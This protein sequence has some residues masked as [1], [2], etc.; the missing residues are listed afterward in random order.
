[1]DASLLDKTE[2]DALCA[3]LAYPQ[4]LPETGL[5]ARHFRGEWRVVFEAL[6]ALTGCS[7][8]VSVNALWE[9]MTATGTASRVPNLGWLMKLEREYVSGGAFLL[10]D[11]KRLIEHYEARELGA[12]TNRIA[13]DALGP[14][15]DLDALRERVAQLAPPRNGH[16]TKAEQSILKAL[17][18]GPFPKRLL[19]PPGL[20]GDVCQWINDT[21]FR[22]QPILT[23]ACV[24]PA[25]GALFGRRFHTPT[26]L[27]TNVYTIGVA[28]TGAGKQHARDQI[29]SLFTL[30]NCPGLLG[31]ER[32]ASGQG[33]LAA[34]DRS[35]SAIFMLDEF[36]ST[37]HEASKPNAAHFHR[38][39][40][41]ILLQLHS[42]AGSVFLG[43]E[44]AKR[45]K[46]ATKRDDIPN[47]NACLYASSTPET[48]YQ[49]LSTQRA[50]DGFLNRMLV[51]ETDDPRPPR[52]V[53]KEIEPPAA[54]LDAVCSARDANSTTTVF[55][56][57]QFSDSTI[58]PES[59]L[60]PISPEAATFLD[61]LDAAVDHELRLRCFKGSAS[62]WQ[63]C[64]ENTLRM[65]LIV[66]VGRDPHN[67]TIE[68]G[69]VTWASEIAL[70]SI[71]HLEAACETRVADNPFEADSK[72]ILAI[73]VAAGE[74]GCLKRTITRSTQ[75]M[76]SR[77]REDLLSN[78]VEGGLVRFSEARSGPK[79]SKSVV[80]HAT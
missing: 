8:P 49:A 19:E 63:R 3:L 45:D 76:E 31:G 36:G 48:F 77:R 37:L 29:K 5:E 68:L 28:P 40:I 17:D 2:R 7:E 53:P 57:V 12:E 56:G 51:F 52:R 75:G 67:P 78:L 79:R 46:K 34:L 50:V 60:V 10:S 25:L 1:M 73:I 65:A 27:R 38:A 74:G 70:W 14:S 58:K 26:N 55:G 30:A 54:L 59:K 64:E 9:Q 47:P 44:Y 41:D 71:R 66:A 23:L 24:I 21:A 61:D 15:P 11:A 4:R 42:S 35:P 62:L 22:P 6:A 33:L 20:V 80:F 43:Q 39:I 72:R 18:P 32:L 16:V 69:D 13:Q